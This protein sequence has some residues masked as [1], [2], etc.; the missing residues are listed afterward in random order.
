MYERFTDNGRK[1]MQLAN[2]EARR[3]NHEYIGTEHLLL[4]L[5]KETSGVA[6]IVLQS[7]EIHLRKIRREVELIVQPLLEMGIREGR[8]PLTPR[9]RF[10]LVLVFVRYQCFFRVPSVA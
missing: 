10:A 6:A 4:G 1:V 2:Y 8:L 7:L 9:A 5:I 3:L